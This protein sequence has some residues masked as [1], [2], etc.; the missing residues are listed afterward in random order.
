MNEQPPLS[1]RNLTKRYAAGFAVEDVSLDLKAG[2]IFGL[3][4]VNGAGKTTLIKAMLQLHGMDAG[5]IRLH[6][7]DARV[8]ESRRDVM[9]LPEKFTPSPLLTGLEFIRLTLSGYELNAL[10]DEVDAMARELTLD[11]GALRRVVKGF[12]K[13]MGQ[14][15][16]LMGVLL[17]KRRLLI[18]DEPMSGLDPAARAELRAAL[19]RYRDAEAG[20]TI[21]FSSHL[22]SDIE[23]MC[24][25][26]GVMHAGRLAFVGTAAEFRARYGRTKDLEAAYMKFLQAAASPKQLTKRPA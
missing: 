6:G 5:E 21:F 26:I 20:R 12:S 9:Y 14:K 17:A 13:G 25:R 4:G 10:P 22:L 1:V 3:I 23:A 11:T 7:V 8:A 18:L 2:E 24:D 19:M 16:G 15:L